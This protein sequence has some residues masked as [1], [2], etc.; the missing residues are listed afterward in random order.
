MQQDDLRHLP[1]SRR[2]TKLSFAKPVPDD[3]QI[4]SRR[5]AGLATHRA[6]AWPQHIHAWDG[7]QPELDADLAVH[8]GLKRSVPFVSFHVGPEHDQ[9][10]AAT[11]SWS[12][13]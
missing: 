1:W 4:A 12:P 5:T 3:P 6:G 10:G 9:E 8:D 11:P 13:Y 7:Q 2:P